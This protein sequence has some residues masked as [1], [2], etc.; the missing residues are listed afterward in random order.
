MEI[1]GTETLLGDFIAANNTGLTTFASDV[2]DISGSVTF[3]NL[4]VLTNVTLREWLSTD[5]LVM[6]RIPN[7]TV[8]D[9]Q[10]DAQ[11]ITNMYVRNTSMAYFVG[12]TL[13]GSQMSVVEIVGNP[14][15]VSWPKKI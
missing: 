2:V 8:I 7:P 9:L 13:Q 10:P 15:L 6:E 4:P 11:Q 12:L 3:S 5:T 1:M 14:Y